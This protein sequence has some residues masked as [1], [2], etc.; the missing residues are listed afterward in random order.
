MIRLLL[1]ALLFFL[2]YTLFQALL[3]SLG[4]QR[5]AP[6]PAR[7]RQGEDM[8]RDAE[9]GTFVPR[10]EALSLS[11]RGETHY[12]CSEKCRDAWLRSH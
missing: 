11:S 8:V 6:P 5:K 4:G 2:G 12:F 7:T 10:S 1:L 9:C 3:R